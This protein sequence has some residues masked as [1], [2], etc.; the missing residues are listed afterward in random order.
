MR[1]RQMPKTSIGQEGQKALPR[2]RRPTRGY[3]DANSIL[4]EVRG[5]PHVHLLAIKLADMP[6]RQLRHTCLSQRILQI[7]SKVFFRPA[8]RELEPS[9]EIN[10]VNPLGLI[11]L[12]VELNRKRIQAL[13]DLG[14]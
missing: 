10:A 5:R 14:L 8:P 11:K 6:Q 4:D 7:P 3:T 12:I 13:V 9:R 1:R 2:P